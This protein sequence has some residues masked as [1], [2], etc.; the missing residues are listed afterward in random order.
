MAS[1]IVKSVRISPELWAFVE[2]RAAFKEISANAWLVRCV[3]D[4]KERMEKERAAKHAR[5]LV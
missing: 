5:P 2:E 1:S 4:A 3:R